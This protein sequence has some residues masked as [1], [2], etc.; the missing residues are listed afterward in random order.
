MGVLGGGGK[1]SSHGRTVFFSFILGLL[2]FGGTQALLTLTGDGWE[3]LE[4][5]P[6]LSFLGG[7]PDTSDL[8][9]LACGLTLRTG[10][11]TMGMMSGMFGL[12]RVTGE[13][14]DGLCLM[15][16]CQG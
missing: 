13:A 10:L 7:P 15:R 14:E 12:V 5:P 1:G 8:S 6:M 2:S 4:S 3:V 16:C 11:L 9:E